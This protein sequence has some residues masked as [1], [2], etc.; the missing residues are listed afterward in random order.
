MIFQMTDA[1]YPPRRPLSVG[2]ILDLTFRIYRATLVTCLLFAALGVM[3]GQLANIYTLARGRPLAQG[4]NALQV[5]L[6]QLRE[7]GIDLLYLVG[8]ILTVVFY[9]AI[10]LRQRAVL[11]ERAAGGEVTAAMR[12]V[13]AVIGLG[14]LYL[15]GCVVCFVPAY[16]TGGSVRVLL[17]FL[18]I[19]VLSYAIVAVSC[20]QT[21]LFI[22]GAGP[23]ASFKRSWRLTSGSFWRLSVIYSVALVILFALYAVTGG[24]A[25]F[26]AG[27]LGHGDF[28]MVT[29]FAGVVG[30]ALG[31]LAT[32]F[33]TAL[34]LAVLGDL[35]VR[36]EG[37]DLE[38]RIS[39][40]A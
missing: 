13:P 27:V 22:D 23:L 19:L 1:L 28:A 2:E 26:L 33:Y 35:S 17:A 14:L 39:A 18:A 36:K 6:A 12:R 10:L 20:A 30:V 16:V 29:A 11:S 32:P 38:Q 25:G 24:V 9:G 15:F 8:A 21:I 40:T 4:P 31:A 5:A 3:A 34:G 37:A 7:P